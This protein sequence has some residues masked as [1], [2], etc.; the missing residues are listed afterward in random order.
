MKK[1]NIYIICSKDLQCVFDLRKKKYYYICDKTKK[2]IEPY[3]ILIVKTT[4]NLI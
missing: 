2:D 3:M 4:G 1:N